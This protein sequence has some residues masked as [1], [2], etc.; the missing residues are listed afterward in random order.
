ME[1]EETKLTA[2]ARPL[3]VAS[4]VHYAVE[5][6]PGG[7]SERWKNGIDRLKNAPLEYSLRAAVADIVAAGRSRF[8]ES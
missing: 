1:C 5:P 4:A 6:D 8:L 7:G 3:V 2:R